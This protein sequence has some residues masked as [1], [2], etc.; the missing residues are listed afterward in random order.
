MGVMVALSNGCRRFLLLSSPHPPTPQNAAARSEELHRQ[1]SRRPP[2]FQVN[3]KPSETYL[4]AAISQPQCMK[5]RS[6]S[7]AQKSCMLRYVRRLP[8]PVKE[9]KAAVQRGTFSLDER[10]RKTNKS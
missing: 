8:E 7:V 10:S 5:N 9:Q 1:P 2:S 6:H 4:H 3:H